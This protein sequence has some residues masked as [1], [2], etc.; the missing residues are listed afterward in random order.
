MKIIR[1]GCK[2]YNTNSVLLVVAIMLYHLPII[3]MLPTLKKKNP[4]VKS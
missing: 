2:L 4:K 1:Q 3:P